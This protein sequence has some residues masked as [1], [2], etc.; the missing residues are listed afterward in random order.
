MKNILISPWTWILPV[1]LAYIVSLCWLGWMGSFVHIVVFYAPMGLISLFRP[2][3]TVNES[4]YMTNDVSLI[5]AIHGVF[6]LSLL[7]G[8]LCRKLLNQRILSF[9]FLVMI[10][11]LIST[12]VGCSQ[13]W[14]APKF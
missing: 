13:H 6:W 12:L 2:D 11:I 14:H 4:G 1:P 3:F 8:L 9:I 10:S 7:C 5:L